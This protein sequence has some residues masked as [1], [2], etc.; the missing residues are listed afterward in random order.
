M[1]R[2]GI[3]AADLNA[4]VDAKDPKWRTKAKTKQA[5]INKS[6]K[7]GKDEGIWSE[8]KDVYMELQGF[9]CMYCE[10]PMPSSK[11]KAPKGTAQGKVEYDVEHFRPKNSV[12]AWLTADVKKL[13]KID[14]D[15][16]LQAPTGTGGYYKLAL[17]TLNYGVSCKTCN[18]ELKGDRF[19]TFAKHARTLVDRAKLDAKEKPCLILPIGDV[20]DD[21]ELV[22]EWLGP[23]VR[24]RGGKVRGR[25]II[26][27]FQLDTRPDLIL[28]RATVVQ[29][30]FPKLEAAAKTGASAKKAKA[31]LAVMTADTSHFAACARA[32]QKLHAADRDEAERWYDLCDDYV[33]SKDASIFE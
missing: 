17:D 7:V 9:K 8:I 3:K 18:S 11:T 2:F 22:L 4:L 29:I 12:K 26:D 19:P 20:A 23:T 31:F 16:Q 25:A 33:I 15:D 24:S 27:F 30:L 32:Y 6:K 21:P 28:L 1:I 5:A 10:K 13:R 14:Y